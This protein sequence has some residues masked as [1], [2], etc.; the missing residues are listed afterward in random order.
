MN[1][2]EKVYL[3][4]QK[5]IISVVIQALALYNLITSFIQ[6]SRDTYIPSKISRSDNP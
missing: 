3:D 1:L 4:F 6:G 2:W 5:K